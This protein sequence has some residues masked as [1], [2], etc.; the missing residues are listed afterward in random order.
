MKRHLPLMLKVQDKL[1]LVVGGGNVAARKAGMLL[2]YGATVLIVSPELTPPLQELV[3]EGLIGWLARPYGKEALDG[4]FLVVAAA[5]DPTVN[6]QVA[7][8]CERRGLPV[9]V[10]D[11]PELCTFIVPA[12]VK[13]GELLIA[14]STAGTSPALAR[15]IREELEKQFDETYSVLLA[16]LGAAREYVKQNI[17]DPVRRKAVLTALAEAELLSVL[18][19]EGTGALSASI[20]TI[21][22]GTDARGSDCRRQP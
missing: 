10:V 4:A 14:V 19:E 20:N 15:C 6:R 18:K 8:D 13:R 16:A 1:C 7:A 5:G 12:V 21:I 22:G 11:A 9:N 2:E 3:K 17:P